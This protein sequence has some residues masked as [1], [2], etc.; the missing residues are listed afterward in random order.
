VTLAASPVT[1]KE[2]GPGFD[3]MP[4]NGGCGGVYATL[5]VRE[6]EVSNVG[7]P[8]SAAGVGEA[9][10]LRGEL[11]SSRSSFVD[12]MDSLHIRREECT[13]RS[14]CKHSGK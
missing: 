13:Q 8:A 12:L 2:H 10:S 9:A 4:T 6:S 5:A 7:R 11:R 1:Q 3:S 14:V